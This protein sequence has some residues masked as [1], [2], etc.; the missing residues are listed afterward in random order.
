[1]NRKAIA[2]VALTALASCLALALAGCFLFDAGI[3]D[4]DDDGQQKIIDDDAAAAPLY[5]T[6]VNH[7]EN[8]DQP[9]IFVFAKNAIPGF[10]ELADGIAWRVM[11]D[12]GR[13]S[14]S[15][16]M[17]LPMCT[18]QATWGG[19][20]RTQSL[21]AEIGKRYTAMEDDTGIVLV[22]N[23]SASQSNAIEVTSEIHVAG[24]I[25]AQLLNDNK[26]LMQEHIVAYGQKASFVVERKLYWGV[27]S[28][29]QE[30]QPIASAVLDSLDFFEQSIDGILG[31]TVT[32]TG[33]VYSGY[34][35]EVESN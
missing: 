25:T 26:L 14:S 17:V 22:P 12:I 30:G 29:I 20:N 11:P 3:D 5:I 32:L 8:S 1:M 16:F 23:G 35:F 24:G 28:E 4:T 9:T 7:S 31:A 18:V 13:G 27:A 21:V 19:V 15:E 33:D 10:D 34:Q 2:L 6:Y